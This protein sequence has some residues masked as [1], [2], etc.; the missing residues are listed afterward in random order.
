MSKRTVDSPQIL[1]PCTARIVKYIAKRAAKNINSLESQTIVPTA[2]AF[3][4]VILWWS[5]LLVMGEIIPENTAPVCLATP[6][7]PSF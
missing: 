1:G 7:T 5:T 3:G 2:T 6:Q 4:R